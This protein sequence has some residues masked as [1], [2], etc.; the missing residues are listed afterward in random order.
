MPKPS[1]KA[2]ISIEE[3]AQNSGTGAQMGPETT[4]PKIT[5]K[6]NST[7]PKGLESDL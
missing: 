4:I 5:K 6:K 3:I 1:K 7:A 2:E